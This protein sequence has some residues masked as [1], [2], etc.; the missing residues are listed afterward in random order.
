MA[1][2]H[3]KQTREVLRSRVETL[4]PN[5]TH[6]WGK[7]TVDQM[8]R[9]L[10]IALG[11]SLGQTTVPPLKMPMPGPLFRFFAVNFPWPKGAPTHP[12]FCVGDRCDFGSEKARCLTLL[13][14]FARKPMES[15]WPESPI[16]GRVTGKFNS[17]LQAKHVDHHLRQFGA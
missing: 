10:N 7:M 13:D 17:R 6:R 14:E 11:V 15:A 4:Q 12:D 9:H 16:F 5:A 1:L 2:L 8:L 3:D